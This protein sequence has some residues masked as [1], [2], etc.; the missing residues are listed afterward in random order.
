LKR[1][2]SLAWQ[3]GTISPHRVL[4]DYLSSPMYRDA[5]PKLLIWHHLEAGTEHPC[6]DAGWWG[7]S[8]MPISRYLAELQRLLAA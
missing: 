1:P 7:P 3:I 6:D 8:A 4:L 2:V 5:R